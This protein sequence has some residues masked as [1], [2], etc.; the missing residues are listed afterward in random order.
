MRETLI[1]NFLRISSNLYIK[2]GEKLGIDA[3]LID[4]YLWNGDCKTKNKK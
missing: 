2:S 4:K 1:N 3:N